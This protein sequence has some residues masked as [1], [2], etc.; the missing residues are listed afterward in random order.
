MSCFFLKEKCGWLYFAIY[1]M[2]IAMYEL[3]RIQDW[4][5]AVVFLS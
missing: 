3:Y 2:R 4:L 5:G 1:Y